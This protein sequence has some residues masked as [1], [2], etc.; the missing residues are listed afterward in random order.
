MPDH[1]ADLGLRSEPLRVM[2]IITSMPVGG[3]ET[4][5]VNLARRLDRNR[6]APELCCLKERG[7]L[8]EALSGEL[9]VF[10][11]LI[12]HKYDLRVLPRLRGLLLRRHIDAVITVGA[13]D[14]MFWGR[15]AARRAGVPVVLAAL[16]STGW[17]DGI[18][19]LNRLLTPWTDAFIAVAEE[20]GRFL[21]RHE[22]FPQH[23]VCVIPNGI[24][25][26][27]FRPDDLARQQIRRELGISRTAPVFGMVA[28]LRPEKNHPL[29]ISAAQRVLRQVPQARFLI[30]GDGPE[31]PK[32]EAHVRQ[33]RME[34]PLLF[35]GNRH[36]VSS[37]LASLDAFVL[38]SHNEANPVSI[39][40]AMSSELPIVATRVGSISEVVRHGVEGFLVD[41]D[42]C[43]AL[44]EL[45]IGLAR[46][47]GQR[48]R[49][50]GA[51]RRRVQDIGCVEAMVG[52]YEGLIESIYRA[53]RG[54]SRTSDCH[55]L[56]SPDDSR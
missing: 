18:G 51:C 49:M 48:R 25:T 50:G 33:C 17:P 27:C 52:G 13:G 2:F 29:L 31:R 42:D 9:P 3:A 53:K 34:H 56:A 26:Q 44:A 45:M 32:L 20:H 14:K 10:C 19:R 1:A 41:P 12:A 22:G 8:G 54:G 7:P 30:V 35:L 46:D 24:D 11:E 23:K 55:Q 4:L 5:L 36:D 6:F 16:H 38:T 40:E 15:L 43:E 21:I 39:L 47:A 28:A 37:V